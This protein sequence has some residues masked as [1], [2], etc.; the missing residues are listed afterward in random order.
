MDCCLCLF[1]YV[2]YSRCNRND[3]LGLAG[4]VKITNPDENVNHLPAVGNYVPQGTGEP[5]ITE[6]DDPTK[7]LLFIHCL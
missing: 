2:L 3:L 5:S 4:M 6:S 7:R 1:M